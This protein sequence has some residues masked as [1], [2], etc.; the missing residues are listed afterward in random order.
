MNI[1]ETIIEH[2]QA[3]TSELRKAADYV[4]AHSN[5]VAVMSMRSFASSANVTPSTLLRLSKLLGFNGWN[6]LKEKQISEL[7]LDNTVSKLN[8]ISYSR[9]AEEQLRNHTSLYH[10]NLEIIKRNIST[11]EESNIDSMKKAVDTIKS[12]ER[13]F[14]FGFK[15]S[16][17]I[18]YYLYY[19]T[20]FFKN[21]IFIIDGLAGNIEL[22][23]RELTANDTVVMIGFEPMSK[24]IDFV[25]DIAAQMMCKKV[26]ITDSQISHI[27]LCCDAVLYAPAS[28]PSFFPSLACGFA[29]AEALVSALVQEGGDGAYRA[30]QHTEKFF[31]SNGSYTKR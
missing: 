20:R 29:L 22:Y 6:E 31:I 23:L 17:S 10:N 26:M 1:K 5:E 30:I 2:S 24:E 7:G 25:F 11:A 16:Y 19:T 18:A 13:V 4:V 9:K 15:A 21:N 28:S 8:P 14:I 3:L 27:S 12:S